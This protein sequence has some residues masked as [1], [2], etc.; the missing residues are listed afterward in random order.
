MEIKD[1]KSKIRKCDA[2]TAEE[3]AML[4]ALI[5]VYQIFKLFNEE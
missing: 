2:F 3:K 4:I 5:A 1:L